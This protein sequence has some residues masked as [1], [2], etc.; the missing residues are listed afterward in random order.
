MYVYVSGEW[1][2]FDLCSD[3]ARACSTG[4]LMQGQREISLGKTRTSA[5]YLRCLISPFFPSSFIFAFLPP[6][7]CLLLVFRC[8]LCLIARS[9]RPGRMSVLLAAQLTPFDAALLLC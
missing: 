1:P 3:N 7:R 9:P 4:V 6:T 2:E 8:F 5:T